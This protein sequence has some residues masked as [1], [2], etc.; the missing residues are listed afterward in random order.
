MNRKKKNKNRAFLPATIN[1]V[2]KKPI[3]RFSTDRNTQK[4]F[5]PVRL[6]SQF[7]QSPPVPWAHAQARE[8]KRKRKQA[9]TP[10]HI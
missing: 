5:F 2:A 7:P 3:I 10:S 6:S 8:R 4:S 9:R 1:H